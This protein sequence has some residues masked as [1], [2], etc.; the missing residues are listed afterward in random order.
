MAKY[1]KFFQKVP[2]YQQTDAKSFD[3][4][5]NIIT[6]FSLEENFKNNT[7]VYNKYTIKDGETPEQLAKRFYG[8]QERHWMILMMNN[9]VDPFYD[10]PLEHKS[11]VNYVT[12]K[13]SSNNYADTANT[14]ISGLNWSRQNTHSYYK[15]I[16]TTFNETTKTQ[17]FEIDSETYA[18]T[19]IGSITI[20]PL[21]DGSQITKVVSRKVKSY[22]DY[23]YELNED[24]REIKILKPEFATTLY[25]ELLRL[26]NQRRL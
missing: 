6:R 17:I 12:N 2:Y 15:V 11:F 22:Y 25:E 1:F 18:N 23:E 5:T 7:S 10:W 26:T 3:I 20:P 8:E 19:E 16:E 14:N 9:V 24:K 13:Y 4:V 21:Q